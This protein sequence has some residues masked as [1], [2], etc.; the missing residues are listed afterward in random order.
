[1]T[2]TRHHPHSPVDGAGS[3]ATYVFAVCGPD[4]PGPPAS[5][6]GHA[7][8][9][10][11]RLLTIGSL[12]AVVQDVPVATFSEAALQERFTDAAEVERCA[13][14]H[15][16]VVTTTAAV[17]PTVPLPLATIYLADDRAVAVLGENQERFRAALDHVA[18]RVEW[19]VKVYVRQP[20]ATSWP[21]LPAPPDVSPPASP[22]EAQQ[23]AGRAYMNRMR[24][25]QRLRDLS[26]E[27]ALA[28][29]EKVDTA[30]RE[31]AVDGV[32]RRLH[33]PEVTG[34][35]RTQVMNAAYLI[36]DDHSEELADTIERLRDSPDFATVSIDISGPWAP[37]SFTDGG[38]LAG[39]Q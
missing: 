13:R 36:P 15:H 38:T 11:L 18:G 7:R 10:P 30:V 29:A 5:T 35:D 2:V 20:D 31:L 19:A 28:A 25:R 6:C 33:G 27:T 34:K 16:S 4:S 14:T 12:C 9:G 26:R 8:G 39:H 24:S 23:G 32:R 1:M 17:G 21:G 22:S 37:Y 3:C